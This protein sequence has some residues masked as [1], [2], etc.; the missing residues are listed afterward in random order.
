MVVDAQAQQVSL[1]RFSPLDARRA[2]QPNANPTRPMGQG[3]PGGPYARGLGQRRKMQL[4]SVHL[5][6]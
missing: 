1:G 4:T 3:K 2:H 5:G 6:A